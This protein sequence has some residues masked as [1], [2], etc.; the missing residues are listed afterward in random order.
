MRVI[1]YQ[2]KGVLSARF[3]VDAGDTFAQ[4]DNIRKLGLFQICRYRWNGLPVTDKAELLSGDWFD[5][6]PEDYT[7]RNTINANGWFVDTLFR[8]GVTQSPYYEDSFSQTTLESKTETINQDLAQPDFVDHWFYASG[9]PAEFD[10][11]AG[12]VNRCAPVGNGG[13]KYVYLWDSPMQ[14]Q[15]VGLEFKVH[16]LGTKADGRYVLGPGFYWAW[17]SHSPDNT[18]AGGSSAITAADQVPDNDVV[19]C[20]QMWVAVNKDAKKVPVGT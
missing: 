17:H 19:S 3:V 2:E 9:M 6:E 10:T 16:L 18:P 7:K 14:A 13:Q 12:A 8:V 1:K 20:L 11:W 5:Q 4:E 15:A